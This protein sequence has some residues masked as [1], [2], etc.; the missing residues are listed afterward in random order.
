MFAAL[1]TS[2]SSIVSCMYG[3]RPLEELNAKEVQK[4][5]S[6]YKIASN[7]S[8]LLD[9]SFRALL[10]TLPTIDS[11][12]LQDLSIY[13][14]CNIRKNHLQ[15]MQIMYFDKNNTLVSYHVNCDMSGFPNLKWN[16]TGNFNTFIPRSTTYPDS[17]VKFDDLAMYISNC[18]SQQIQYADFNDA[19][20]NIV[21]F[22]CKCF[23]RQSKRVIKL[24]RENL[25]INHSE[26]VNLLFVNID[27]FGVKYF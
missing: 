1:L 12:C 15:P 19:D 14:F 9:T 3:I 7:E 4:I 20:Y 22:W 13:P 10:I 6:K 21:I 11:N 25:Q 18:N 5:A 2:C 23:G 24:V 8:F 17:Y 16:D 27:N 26:K